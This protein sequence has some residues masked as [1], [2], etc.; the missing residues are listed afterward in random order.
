MGYE[1]HFNKVFPQEIESN[2]K[3]LFK[4]YSITPILSGFANELD[5]FKIESS[6]FYVSRYFTESA[7]ENTKNDVDFD[8]V[9]DVLTMLALEGTNN[10]IDFSELVNTTKY[11]NTFQEEWKNINLSSVYIGARM[12][13]NRKSYKLIRELIVMS[14]EFLKKLAIVGNIHISGMIYEIMDNSQFFKKS[15][16]NVRKYVGIDRATYNTLIYLVNEDLVTLYQCLHLWE[17]DDLYDAILN[18]EQFLEK[19]K[20]DF[21]DNALYKI[22]EL[23][24][25]TFRPYY[26]RLYE[27][28]V[29]S[30]N[31]CVLGNLSSNEEVFGEI[32]KEIS[33][34]SRNKNEHM[35]TIG[36]F[37]PEY[38]A[39]PYPTSI[40]SF[41]FYITRLHV[42]K[43]NGGE[44]KN[45]YV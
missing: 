9:K 3:Y 13:H 36:G 21:S 19:V 41:P 24:I 4:Y 32:L 2:W 30:G 20:Y 38:Q 39:L 14:T 22:A 10:N 5:R 44:N 33:S 15:D 27:M 34:W 37:R 8:D 16:S 35:L 40:Q 11:T 28:L 45:G 26:L 25:R 29:H 12:D 6:P 7:Y 43:Q 18:S 31:F 1:D 23:Y 17:I 42:P